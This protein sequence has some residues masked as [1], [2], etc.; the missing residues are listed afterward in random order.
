MSHSPYRQILRSEPG[1]VGA[2]VAGLLV[3]LGIFALQYGMRAS[4]FDPASMRIFPRLFLVEDYPAT[5]LLVAA[6]AVGLLPA[7]QRAALSLVD[8]LGARPVLACA[9]ALPMLALGTL[10]VYK[11][12]PLSMDEYAPYLQSQAFAA[13]ELTGRFRMD[14]LDWLVWPEF[15]GLFIHVERN[16]GDVASAYWPGF[17]LLLTPFTAV[18]VPWLCNPVIGTAGLWVVHRLALVLTQSRSVAGAAMLL[19]LGSAAF[20]TYSISFYS[21]TAHLVCNA[22]FVLLLLNPTIGRC[23]AAGV[24]GGLALNLHNPVPHLFFAAPWLAWM[25]WRRE[26]RSLVA[27]GVGYLPW[28]AVGFGWHQ[29]LHGLADGRP[30]AGSVGGGH[31]V[32]E[33]F[34]IFTGIFH[35][36]TQAQML[37]RLIEFAKLWLWAAPGLLFLAAAG[38]RMHRG[39]VRWKL[40]LASALTTLIGHF[41]VPLNQGHGWGFRY[42][43]SAWFVLPLLGAA[44]LAA[45]PGG[46][47][48][49]HGQLAAYGIGLGLVGL[50]M[51]TPLFAYQVHQFIG[52]HLAQMPTSDRGAPRV[53]IISTATGYYAQDLG[54]NDAFLRNPVIVLVSRGRK[55][56]A[57]MMAAAFPNLVLLSQSNRGSVWGTPTAGVAT[58]RR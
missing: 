41:F 9:V 47:W 40:L 55:A 58:P 7:V 14:I 46:G 49:L 4:N 5:L 21:M 37:D 24:V 43:H 15:Q 16:S 26:W 56:D 1:V 23:L 51:M 50:V 44:V 25:A 36:P 29:L 52:A 27:L 28:V 22:T 10:M 31:P 13:G 19:T 35:W 8:G 53:A 20:T 48:R 11:Q 32:L 17:A 3:T 34:T 33:A 2:V 45:P 30:V 38:Y 39:D 6:L 57:A 54:Q 12:H 42:F 18:G